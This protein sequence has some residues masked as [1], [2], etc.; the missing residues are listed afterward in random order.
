MNMYCVKCKS[1]TGTKEIKYKLTKNNRPMING[2]CV[3]CSK[4]KS[5]FISSAE[6][7]KAKKGGIIFTLPAILGA[8]GAIGSLAGGASAIANAVNKKKTDDKM[9]KETIRHNKAM[10]KK[11]SGKGLFLKPYKK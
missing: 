4:M 2:K 5:Q 11:K 9:I 1:K 8:V 7:N 3:K 6:A 10:E